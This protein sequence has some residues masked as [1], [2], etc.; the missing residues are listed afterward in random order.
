MHKT[1]RLTMRFVVRRGIHSRG[2]GVSR[3]TF[4]AR[5]LRLV[6]NNLSFISTS[7]TVT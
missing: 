2:G 5:Q 3:G 6:R 7:V 4:L 1:N